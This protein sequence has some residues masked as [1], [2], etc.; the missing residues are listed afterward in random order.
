MAGIFLCIVLSASGHRTDVWGIGA[1]AGATRR[2]RRACALSC[3]LAVV[4]WLVL[5]GAPRAAL[6]ETIAVIMSADSHHRHMSRD[7]LADIY[8][9]KIRLDE[10]GEAWVPVNLPATDPLRRSFSV[11]LFDREP[12]A[13]E[14]YWN[15][16]YFH[17]V[18]PPFVLASVE[19]VLRFVAKT[20]GAIGYVADCQVD[21]R[22][23]VVLR[24]PVPPGA[25]AGLASL[26]PGTTRH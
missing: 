12:E 8:R 15:A 25:A 1:A 10:D 21:A 5:A 20:P 14:E 24:L 17:G 18:S 26:C 9:R 13:M 4:A 7:T 2:P 11:L 22:V 16:Q 19:A 3:L 23:R 6:A